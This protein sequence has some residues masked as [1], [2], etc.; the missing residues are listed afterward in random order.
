MTREKT[1]HYSS[2]KTPRL[3]DVAMGRLCYTAQRKREQAP[4]A[5]RFIVNDGH[6]YVYLFNQNIKNFFKDAVRVSLGDPGLALFLLQTIRRQSRASQ[7][8]LAWEERGVHVPPFM[9]ASITKRCNLQCKG[10]YAR[11]LHR[12]PETEM[13]ASKLRS[14]IAEARDLGIS[15]ILIAGGEPLTRPE[16]LDITGDFPDVM[17]P[18]F[19]NGLLIGEETIQRLKKQ[20]N[21]VPVIS[22][23]GLGAQTDERRGQGM[24]ELILNRMALLNEQDVFFGTSLT[25]TGQ[26]LTD[27][28]DERFIRRLI[29]SGC[30]LFFFVDYVPAQ[31]GTEDLVLTDEQRRQESSRLAALRSKLPGLFVAFPGDEGMYGGCLAAGRGFV[32]V[33]PEGRLEPCPFSPFSDT[34]LNDLSLKEALQ[35]QF[36]KK[37]RESD[38]HLGETNGGCA[39]WAKREWVGSLLEPK[40][41]PISEPVSQ[42]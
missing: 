23:E 27:V 12:S 13:S 32:H 33:S 40:V 38:S 29:D 9:I 17:F 24:Y 31:E 34:S 39:L 42:A 2:L 1:G 26:N 15:I 19:T 10:C 30:K 5:G 35:S 14:V 4:N 18:L 8:R 11:A 36:L 41:L 37:I 25:V 3:A 16:I 20:R 28:T 21:V 7:V 6:D 22:M